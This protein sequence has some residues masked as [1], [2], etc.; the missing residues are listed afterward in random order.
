MCWF[1][2]KIITMKHFLFFSIVVF[3]VSACST[4]PDEKAMVHNKGITLVADGDSKMDS[5]AYTCVGC[6]QWM[7]DTNEFSLVVR[8]ASMR[9]KKGLNIPN[10]FNP[11]SMDI[12]YSKEDSLYHAETGAKFDSVY[13]AL[14]IYKYR[15]KNAYG[16]ELEGENTLLFYIQ[17]GSVASIEEQIKLEPLAAKEDGMNRDLSLYSEY[18]GAEINISPRSDKEF[19]VRSSARCVEEGT[20]LLLKLENDQDVK[21]VSWNDFNCD[22]LCFFRQLSKSQIDMLRNTP[23][24]AVS[25]IG[26]DNA[27]TL[28]PKNKSDY[29]MQLVKL[30]YGE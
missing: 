19:I 15:G 21:L 27:V 12:Y 17:N 22:G 5:V 26:G 10:S 25:V 14:V 16:T 4:K 2:Y 30:W 6:E 13:Q 9:A 29:F 11:V 23:L 24:K 3:T 28:V 8:E 1:A 7:K 20:W 18:N